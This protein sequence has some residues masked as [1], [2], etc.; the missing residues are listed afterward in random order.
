MKRSGDATTGSADG[1]RKRTAGDLAGLAMSSRKLRFAVVCHSNQ[2]RSMEAHNFLQRRNYQ[3]WSY[4]TGAQVKMPGPTPEEPNCYDY[5][6]ET[7]DEMHKD[8]EAKDHTLYTQNGLLNMLDRN[9]NIKSKPERWQSERERT[10]DVVITCESRVFD[11]VLK[12]FEDRG[13]SSEP[14]HVCNVE[15]TDN[16]ESATIGAFH[17]V[18]LC[19]LLEKAEDLEDEIEQVLEDFQESTKQ[20]VLHSVGFY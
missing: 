16:H 5:G 2:N 6:K 3:I 8:L 19:A 9:R 18:E 10:F 20:E 13:D 7:Y 11:E 15:I 12:D 1:N 17:I 4:G 14:V